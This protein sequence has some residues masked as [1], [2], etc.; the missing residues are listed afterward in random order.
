M[1]DCSHLAVT[2]FLSISEHFVT[3]M[4]TKKI[5]KIGE[6]L[7]NSVI[8]WLRKDDCFDIARQIFRERRERLMCICKNTVDMI[9]ISNIRFSM[10]EIREII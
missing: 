2:I 9:T 6:Y 4:V 8:N 1:F 3:N 5:D 7:A 10:K